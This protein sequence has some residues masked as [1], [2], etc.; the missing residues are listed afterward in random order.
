[1]PK[2]IASLARLLPRRPFSRPGYGLVATVALMGALASGPLAAAE[3]VVG[4]FSNDWTGNGLEV[5]AVDDPKIKGITCHLVDFDRSVIDRL[6]RGNWFE[7][8][9]N[10]SISCRRTGPLVIGDIDLS[11]KGEE[12]FSERKSLVF[13]SIAIRRIYDRAN[14]TLVY[15]VYSRQVKDSSAKMSISTVPL[16]VTEPVWERGKPEK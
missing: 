1:M 9:S 12:V 3:G 13:K 8:P 11:S 16:F 4:R 5:Q 2:S 10:A 15:V 14:D 6:T 7:D